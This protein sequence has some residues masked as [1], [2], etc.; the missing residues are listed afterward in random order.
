M[1]RTLNVYERIEVEGSNS[2]WHIWRCIC[3]E[4]G[5]EED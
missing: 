3:A 1:K 4:L 5:I 2:W